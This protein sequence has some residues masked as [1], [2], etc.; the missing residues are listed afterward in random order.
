[1]GNRPVGK[2]P[3]LRFVVR[4]NRRLIEPFSAL[5]HLPGFVLGLPATLFLV[6]LNWGDTGRVLSVL[7]YGISL[8]FLFLISTLFHA[9][10]LPSDRRHRL[11]RLDHM[12]IFFFIGGTYTPIAYNMA[13]AAWRW[14]LLLLV[15]GLCLLGIGVKGWAPGIHGL[16]QTLLYVV[17]SWLGVVPVVLGAFPNLGLAHYGWLLAGGVAYTL[18]YIVYYWHWPDPWPRVFGHHEVWHLAVLAGAGCHYLF[19]I[20]QLARL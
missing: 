10:H 8:T 17:I 12:A 6:W 19:I 14:P 1:M 15:W 18:G 16:W 13:A 20:T 2:R 3:L 4:L 7:L 5:T 11:N 9:L